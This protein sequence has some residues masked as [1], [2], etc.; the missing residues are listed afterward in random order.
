MSNRLAIKA[1][2]FSHESSSFFGGHGI[3]I[4]G[5]RVFLAKVE[6]E[7]S[8]PFLVHLLVCV[9]G[10]VASSVLHFRYCT[11]H[12]QEIILQFDC[13]SY[14][15]LRSVGDVERDMMFRWRGMGRVSLK[16][17]TT[18]SFFVSFD[19]VTNILNLATCSSMVV[20]PILSSFIS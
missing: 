20:L 8:G 2:S 7:P 17:S 5:I 9:G 11:F 15:P 16:Y 13:R 14:Q 18:A 4:H 1:C 10:S 12:A 6:I 3:D 19:L